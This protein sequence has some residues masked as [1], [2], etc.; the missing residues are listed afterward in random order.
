MRLVCEFQTEK[1]AFSFQTY[2]QN[3][4]VKSVY[5]STP[6]DVHVV[7]R[8]WVIEEDDFEKAAS[9]YTEWMQNPTQEPIKEPAQKM[10]GTSGN[11]HRSNW[12]VRVDAPRLRSPFSI[13][14]FMIILC[15]FLFFWM[16]AQEVRLREEHGQFAVQQEFVP[17][18]QTLFFDYPVYMVN[19]ANFINQNDVKTAD[20]FKKLPQTTQY[21]YE[22][23]LKAPTWVGLSNM[24]ATRDWNLYEK[25]PDGTLFGKIRE[26]EVWRLIT[27][28]LLHEGPLHILFNMLWLFILG[29]QIEERIGIVRYIF[30]SL[31][32]GIAGNVAQYLMSG[33]D[34]LGYSGIVTGMVGFI[35]I[36]QKIAPWEGY[37]LQKPVI[38]FI[39]VFV[40]AMLAF[41]VF[42]ISLKFFHIDWGGVALANT[43]HVIGGLFGALLGRLSMFA[44]AH[45]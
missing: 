15:G 4:G 9:Y 22:K 3:H 6:T 43:A 28:V 26:G 5:D 8:L 7:Y 17:L 32:I 31:L 1:E 30:L 37:P 23:L 19:I 27:P 36:R 42:V 2:L 29:R 20:D 41:E 34:F 13:N 21:E 10:I 25:L 45:P 40:L 38:I 35:W 18:A 44:R 33:P 12:R 16:W 24:I 39:T 11:A 14:N